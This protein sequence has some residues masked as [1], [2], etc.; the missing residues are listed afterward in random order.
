MNAR[1]RTPM[2]SLRA[3]DLPDDAPGVY[4]LYRDGTPMYVG[5]AEKQSLRGRFWGSHRGRG[6]SMTGSALRRNVAE[7][8]DIA[9]ARAIK[10]REYRPM[11]GDARRVVEWIDGC[12]VAW[13]AC[14]TPQ[15]AKHMERDMKVEAKPPL[16]Q[17]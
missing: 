9:S 10:K 6:V 12:E 8:L 13:I 2:A 11:P 16:T 15:E 14:A 5:L 7:H 4:A 17:R 3:E 1:P